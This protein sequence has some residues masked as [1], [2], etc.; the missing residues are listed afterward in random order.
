MDEKIEVEKK[1]INR[2]KRKGGACQK[3]KR[4]EGECGD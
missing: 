3:K 2:G 4:N 1:E